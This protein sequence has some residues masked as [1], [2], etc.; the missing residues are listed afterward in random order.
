M[1][2]LL[3]IPVAVAGLPLVH[4][5]PLQSQGHPW[6]LHGRTEEWLWSNVERVLQKEVGSLVPARLKELHRRD[7]CCENCEVGILPS[8]HVIVMTTV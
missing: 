8:L 2:Q 1:F 3:F 6:L 5:T 7:R 4:R